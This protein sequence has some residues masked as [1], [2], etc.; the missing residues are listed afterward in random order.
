MTTARS[1]EAERLLALATDYVLEHGVAGV[2]LSRLA[3]SI[4]S[5][6]RMLLYYF[7]SKEQLIAAA[8]SAAYDRFPALHGLL[9][10]LREG[11]ELTELIERG[12]R[13][14]RDPENAAFLTLFFEVFA[15]A[16]RDPDDHRA[17]LGVLAAHWPAEMRHVFAEHGYSHEEAE[18]AMLQLLALWRGMQF[19]LLSGLDVADLDA[20]HDAAVRQLFPPRR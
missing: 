1:P 5:N 20:A 10:G 6:N 8:T 15:L 17:H 11:G 3:Q 19:S 18:L 7:G 4:G 13:R 12:W 9:P 2:S 14:L 16:A